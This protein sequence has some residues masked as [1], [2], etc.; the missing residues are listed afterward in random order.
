[1][2]I[3]NDTSLWVLIKWKPSKLTVDQFKTFIEEV[4]QNK[5]IFSSRGNLAT[6]NEI[7]K[8]SQEFG[9]RFSVDELKA[10]S[11]ENISRVKV[12]R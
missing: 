1:L 3:T 6:A 2:D 8:I 5:E 11:K 4:Q 9:F 12:K 10:I 7:T